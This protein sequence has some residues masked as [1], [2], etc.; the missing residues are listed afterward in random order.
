MHSFGRFYLI[1]KFILPTVN[2]LKFLTINFNE[3]CEYLQDKNGHNLKARQYI[4]DFLVYCRKIVPFIHFYRAQISSF[5]CTVHSILNKSLLILP[6]LT[7][8]TK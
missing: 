3:T 1:T 8:I 7:E 6:K 4:S 2:D 5:N